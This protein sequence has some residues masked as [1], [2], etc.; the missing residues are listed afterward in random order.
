MSITYELIPLDTLFFRGNTPMEAGQNTATSL[1]PPPLSVLKGAFR[2]EAIRQSGYDVKTYLS[3]NCDSLNALIGAPSDDNGLEIEQFF[4]R[5]QNRSFVPAPASWYLD[6]PAKPKRK[7]DYCKNKL[8]EALYR[9]KAITELHCFSSS[10]PLPF[11]HAETTAQ[12]LNGIWISVDFLQS[13]KQQLNDEDFLLPGEIYVMENRI[14]VGLDSDKHTIE[15]K[16]YSASHIRLREDISF[17]VT[18]PED[19]LKEN[20]GAIPLGGEQRICFYKK[21]EAIIFP[22]QDSSLFLSTIPLPATETLLLKIFSSGKL[23]E[24]AGWDFAK[25]FH[26]ATTSWIPAGAVFNEKINQSCIALRNIN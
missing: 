17:C 11:V 4:I 2:S 22:R 9:N 8:T 5:K 18:L 6:S 13:S 14:G 20:T 10:E 3:G 12:P 19:V 26:K 24:T 7:K 21:T 23:Y 16:L 15:G 25:G 1:F